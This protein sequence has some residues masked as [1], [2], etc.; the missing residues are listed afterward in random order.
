MCSNGTASTIK[1]VAGDTMI[2]IAKEKLGIPFPSLLA[3][4]L[5]VKNPDLTNVGDVLN[6]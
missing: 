1:V 6:S 4:N 3:A 5:Q 2:I